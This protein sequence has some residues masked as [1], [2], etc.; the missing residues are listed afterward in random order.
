MD[1]DGLVKFIKSQGCKVVVYRKKKRICGNLGE[2]IDDPYPI[3]KIATKGHSKRENVAVLLHEY[4]HFLQWRVGFGKMLDGIC[5]SHNVHE[6]WVK[7][8]IELTDREIEMVRN[9]MLAI[10]YDADMRGYRVGMEMKPDNFDPEHFLREAHSYASS[11][12]W[13]FDNRADWKKRPPWRFWD[14]R[15]LTPE[16]LFAP[17]TKKEK[18]ILKKIKKKVIK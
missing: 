6:E 1:F 18:V 8:E 4:G 5:W 13:A 7:G 11:I 14:A 2:F 3:I 10:E 16:Q 9:V 12:K 17:L 15:V